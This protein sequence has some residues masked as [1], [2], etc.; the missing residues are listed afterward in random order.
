MKR[1]KI[2]LPP[3]PKAFWH[4]VWRDLQADRVTPEVNAATELAN[5]EIPD[6][7]MDPATAPEFLAM[8]MA[9]QYLEH[10]VYDVWHH[11][12]FLMDRVAEKSATWDDMFHDPKFL[13]WRA[14]TLIG[15]RA[16]KKDHPDDQAPPT[17]WIENWLRVRIAE[18]ADEAK[19]AGLTFRPVIKNR[20]PPSLN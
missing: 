10:G 11:V 20:H 15:A 16:W 9:R 17:G 5:N 7:G 2:K 4:K 19:A 18:N 8:F 6:C 14:A 12:G 3:D 1:K 13:A